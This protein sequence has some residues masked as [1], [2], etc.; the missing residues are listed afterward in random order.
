MAQ[1]GDRGTSAQNS[2]PMKGRPNWGFTRS[3]AKNW[4]VTAAPG[5]DSSVLGDRHLERRGCV[6]AL[7]RAKFRRRHAPGGAIA[8]SA[9]NAVRYGRE[10]IAAL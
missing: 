8:A 7:W 2:A 9:T 6:A 4:A 10:R 1:D 5:T 3:A